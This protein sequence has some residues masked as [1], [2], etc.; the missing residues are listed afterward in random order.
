MKTPEQYRDRAET[1][2]RQGYNCAQAVF[3][4]L[5]EDM[6]MDWETGARLASSFGGGMGRLREVCGA[7]SG[8]FLAAGLRSGYAE[9]EDQAAKAAHY[10]LI[11]ELAAAFRE[12]N[13]SIICRELLG[14]A[15]G[16]STPN[17]ETRTP[18]FYQKRPCAALVGSAAETA[19]RILGL[20]DAQ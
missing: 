9:P 6:G 7:V 16:A 20:G 1:L 15:Q 18:E 4:A 11:Q 19:A 3:L 12:Q 2:F 8:M 5:G 17:P 14:L 13:G 10:A